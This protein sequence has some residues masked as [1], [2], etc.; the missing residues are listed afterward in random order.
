MPPTC[1]ACG[2]PGK[3]I[4]CDACA[5]SELEFILS[6]RAWREVR[7][8]TVVAELERDLAWLKAA[9]A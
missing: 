8:P 1:E 6:S 3:A 9:F 5:I 7:G 2:A 4:R